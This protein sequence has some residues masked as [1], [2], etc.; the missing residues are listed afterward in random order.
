MRMT[1]TKKKKMIRR[2]VSLVVALAMLLNETYIWSI[3]DTIPFMETNDKS[4]QI[5]AY[6]AE[7]TGP[8]PNFTHDDTTGEIRVALADF[9]EYSA[10]CQIYSTYHQYDQVKLYSID[11]SD[12]F[13]SGFSGLGTESKPF[14]GSV[15]IESNTYLTLNLDAP[16]FNYVYDSVT[17]NNGNALHISRYYG[18]ES[19]ADK[20][21]PAVAR[22]V[23]K[24]SSDDVVTWNIDL[25]TPSDSTEH[26]LSQF[27]G[28]IGT[29]DDKYGA[30]NLALNVTMNTASMTKNDVTKTDNG[31]V[32]VIGSGDLGLACGH[33]DAGAKLS[34]T[35]TANRAISGISTDGG[36]VDFGG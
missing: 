14:G 2:S 31:A 28:F 35:Y 20:T 4:S 18:V 6:A 33:M 15:E 36:D 16:L 3:I 26:Y 7:E 23:Y 1:G 25:T 17:I 22:Y 24:G 27:G 8:D 12:V 29:M 9:V 13:E 30:P 32:A 34:F 5:T 11:G 10:A 21:A 19:G